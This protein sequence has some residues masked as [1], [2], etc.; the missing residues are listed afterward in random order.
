MQKST[1]TLRDLVCCFKVSSIIDEKKCPI[2]LMAH[3]LER[4]VL[5]QQKRGG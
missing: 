3:L 5:L 4:T 2:A 1:S